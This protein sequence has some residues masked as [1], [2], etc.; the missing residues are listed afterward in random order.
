M[1]P[2]LVP[3][4]RL[5]VARL[6]RRWPV[7]PGDLVAASD[8]R[9]PGRLIVK[10]VAAVD[11]RRVRLAGDNPQ[12]STDSRTFG[13]VDRRAVWGRVWYRYAPPDRTGRP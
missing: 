3:G 10:R 4:D 7:R 11:G 6:P 2:A 1:T 8:P 9:D 5:V 13:P 12:A